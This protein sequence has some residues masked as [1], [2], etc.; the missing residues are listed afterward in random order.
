MEVDFRAITVE[1]CDSVRAVRGC[2]RVSGRVAVAG[3]AGAPRRGARGRAAARG[4]LPRAARA[5]RQVPALPP[6]CLP[7]PLESQV[8]E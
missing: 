5:V 8:G 7:Q 4:A 2:V 6:R 1:Q 3:C